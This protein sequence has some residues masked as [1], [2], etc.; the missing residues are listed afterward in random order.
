MKDTRIIFFEFPIFGEQSEKLAKIGLAVY[1]LEPGKYVEFHR[2]MMEFK[3]SATAEEA[4]GFAAKIGVERTAI[5]KE[6]ANPKYA[7]LATDIKALGEKLKIQGTPFLIIG[8]EPVPHALDEAGL[9]EYM[10]KA[11]QAKVKP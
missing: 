7:T 6:L 5:E 11:R 1:A 4:Y 10:E 9:K 2:H 3:G 8:E